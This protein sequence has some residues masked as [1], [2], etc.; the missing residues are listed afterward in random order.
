MQVYFDPAFRWTLEVYSLQLITMPWSN[1]QCKVWDVKI[2]FFKNHFSA[3]GILQKHILRLQTGP[4]GYL[5]SGVIKWAWK[6]HKYI[7]TQTQRGRFKWPHAIIRLTANFKFGLMSDLGF[8]KFRT[9]MI[10]HGTKCPLLRPGVINQHKPNQTTRVSKHPGEKWLP[11]HT[12]LI[13]LY[14]FVLLH[15]SIIFCVFCTE[16]SDFVMHL[17]ATLV[18]QGQLLNFQ[19]E[20][21][22]SSAISIRMVYIA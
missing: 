19:N 18:S 22:V 1:S 5:P 21:T 6:S 10:I 3:Y 4:H 7:P 11:I 9:R 14:L 2:L 13:V 17:I 8:C 12:R 20:C 16:I 15:S